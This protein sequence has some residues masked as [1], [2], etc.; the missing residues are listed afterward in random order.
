MGSVGDYS[1]KKMAS[2]FSF[3]SSDELSFVFHSS[4]FCV[5]DTFVSL[6]QAGEALRVTGT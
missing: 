1:D 6:S 4:C 5:S 2:F 3:V